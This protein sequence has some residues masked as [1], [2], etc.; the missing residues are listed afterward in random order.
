MHLKEFILHLKSLFNLIDSIVKNVIVL[1]AHC[2]F[3]EEYELN[4]VILKSLIVCDSP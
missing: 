3:K 2:P 1:N 4:L